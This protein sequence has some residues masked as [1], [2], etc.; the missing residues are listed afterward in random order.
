MNTYGI[1]SININTFNKSFGEPDGYS[2]DVRNWFLGFLRV[3]NLA[4]N[5]L[6]YF[7]GVSVVSGC[8]R[9]GTGLALIASAV[10]LK[11]HPCT[12]GLFGND[13]FDEA[14]GTGITQIAR[15]ALESFIPL[16]S[17]LNFCLDVGSTPFNL[18]LSQKTHARKENSTTQGPYEEPPYFPPFS[19]LYMA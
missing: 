12:H 17:L 11:N 5:I 7:P 18:Y 10:V 3:H 8:V 19:L 6:G 4:L 14:I 2:R 15:G 16:G 9:M 13:R 1:H